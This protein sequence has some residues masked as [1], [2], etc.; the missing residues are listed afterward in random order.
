MQPHM[1]EK[2]GTATDI[3]ASLLEDDDS[4]DQLRNNKLCDGNISPVVD[5]PAPQGP[6]R[7]E[8]DEEYLQLKAAGV[9]FLSERDVFISRLIVPSLLVKFLVGRNRETLRNF[10]QSFNIKIDVPVKSTGRNKD[11][12]EAVDTTTVQLEGQNARELVTASGE[13]RT[14]LDSH[15]DRLPVTH[16]ISIPM[17]SNN[18]PVEGQGDFAKRFTDLK[19]QILAKNYPTIDESLFINAAKAHMTIVVLRL[20]SVQETE[21]C[22]LAMQEASSAIYDAVGTRCLVLHLKG[23]H[24]MTDDPSA[25]DVV[26]TT[27]TSGLT[28]N[29]VQGS[30]HS[31]YMAIN[32]IAHV[33]FTSLCN[34]GVIT[35][36]Q[37]HKQRAMAPD[38][39]HASLKLHV[40]LLNT[41]FRRRKAARESGS[42]PTRGKSFQIGA[43]DPPQRRVGQRGS[44]G[45]EDTLDSM[46]VTTLLREFSQFD[47]GRFR[48]GCLELNEFEKSE[49]FKTMQDTNVPRSSAAYYR[50][51]NRIVL[52]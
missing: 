20:L 18:E 13:I 47:F 21:R 45:G 48:V 50:C 27:Q 52:P 25:T 33:L 36:D 1:P 4:E 24:A 31:T 42:L 17:V 49:D 41:K 29:N 6:R 51:V 15:R 30:S 39:L 23:L 40:T 35:V 5:G 34:H 9:E 46:D 32:S 19:Q 26:Y 43:G 44:T 2:G 8:E 11:V 37:L 10:E 14:F 12:R 7:V 28:N 3:E 38:G 22:V 16:M